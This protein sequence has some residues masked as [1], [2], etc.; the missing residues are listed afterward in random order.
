M[1]YLSS[2]AENMI[3]CFEAC[4]GGRMAWHPDQLMDVDQMS[5][6]EMA[7]AERGLERIIQMLPTSLLSAH[8]VA[9]TVA[10]LHLTLSLAPGAFLHG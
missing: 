1:K 7:A 4:Q 2:A 10:I 9:A 8:P 5:K 6:E 3:E